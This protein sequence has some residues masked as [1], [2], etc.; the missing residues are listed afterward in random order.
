MKSF[1]VFLLA[2]IA[3]LLAV[4]S[5]L[6]SLVVFTLPAVL[7]VFRAGFGAVAARL[8]AGVVAPA[9]CPRHSATN[10][11]FV[12]PLA[13]RVALLAVHSSLHCLPVFC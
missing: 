7:G 11:F 12:F 1:F 4:H 8:G 10:A 3:A 13:W 5:A 2:W 9:V 6:H